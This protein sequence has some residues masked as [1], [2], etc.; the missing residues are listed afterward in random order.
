MELYNHINRIEYESRCPE[1]EK[2][3]VVVDI[4]PWYNSETLS[5]KKKKKDGKKMPG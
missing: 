3:I 4:S 2:T 1:V 5:A